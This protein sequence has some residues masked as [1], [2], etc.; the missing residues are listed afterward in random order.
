MRT[1]KK[2]LTIV[3]I[4][5]VIAVVILTILLT[6]YY[7]TNK[8]SIP[9]SYILGKAEQKG[10]IGVELTYD[11]TAP[12]II[13]ISPSGITYTKTTAA[14][15]DEDIRNKT[16]TLYADS[17]E[18]GSE[19]SPDKWT[20]SFNKGD[21]RSITY[22]FVNMPSPTP[23]I[24]HTSIQ[25]LQNT[26]AVI[27]TATQL[28]DMRKNCRYTIELR[29]EK[30]GKYIL[31]DGKANLNA[32][33]HVIINIPPEAFTDTEGFIRITLKTLETPPKTAIEE[34]PVTLTLKEVSNGLDNNA[35]NTTNST[36]DQNPVELTITSEDNNTHEN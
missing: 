21:N 27:F 18:L 15:Y 11:N 3:G 33:T 35:N 30:G 16:I 29:T 23:Y 20:V 26:Y 36:S 6:E 32:S 1:T 31:S 7:T 22:R 2:I 5:T 25:E 14:R 17:D 28:D 8:N 34:L 9:Q 12:D 4:I 10:Y 19:D 24:M 13:L